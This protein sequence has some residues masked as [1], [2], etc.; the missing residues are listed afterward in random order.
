VSN[1]VA[2]ADLATAMPAI[3]SALP[4]EKFQTPKTAKAHQSMFYEVSSP[5]FNPTKMIFVGSFAF[6]KPMKMIF[7]GYFVF[8]NPMEMIFKGSFVFFNPTEMIFVGS[9]VF[10]NPMKM[11]FK[12]SFVF[13][14]PTEIIFEGSFVA[15]EPSSGPGNISFQDNDCTRTAG[16][17]TIALGQI[18]LANLGRKRIKIFNP[19]RHIWAN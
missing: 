19:A 13:F 11:I 17:E 2:V 16:N 14:N 18:T 15:C 4:I 8:F 9:F 1:P 12:G 3:P 5:F 6:F 7:K 10:F